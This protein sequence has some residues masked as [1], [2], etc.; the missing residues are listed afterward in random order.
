MLDHT[1]TED[2]GL[3]DLLR[4]TRPRVSPAATARVIEA[5]M[6][7]INRPSRLREWHAGWLASWRI[8]FAGLAVTGVLLGLF[9]PAAPEPVAGDQAVAQL[10]AD[11]LQ[12][13][14]L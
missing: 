8:G 9:L 13:D 14:L 1:D 2:A 10:V 12:G 7:R 3:A 5:A 11:A 6:Q 4:R